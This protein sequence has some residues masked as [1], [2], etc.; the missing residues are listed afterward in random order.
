MSLGA[1]AGAVGLVAALAGCSSNMPGRSR[2]SAG[3]E[4]VEAA[5]V[6]LFAPESGAWVTEAMP[7]FQWAVPASASAWLDL[8]ADRECEHV[9]E[10]VE[11]TGRRQ[12]RLLTGSARELYWRVRTTRSTSPIWLVRRRPGRQPQGGGYIFG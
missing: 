10:T 11:V 6:R 12:M 1:L 5:S 3:P 4:N 2:V 7:L 8:C 9:V